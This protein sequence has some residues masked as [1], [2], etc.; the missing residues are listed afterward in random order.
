MVFDNDH[1]IAKMEIMRHVKTRKKFGS[2]FDGVA[3]FELTAAK[4]MATLLFAN[5]AH[6]GTVKIFKYLVRAIVSAFRAFGV[7]P[8]KLYAK[9]TGKKVNNSKQMVR[10]TDIVHTLSSL[11]DLKFYLELCTPSTGGKFANI[12]PEELK[13]SKR[14]MYL[15]PFSFDDGMKIDFRSPDESIAG[16]FEEFEKSGSIVDICLVD[17]WHT[18]QTA[19]RDISM[20]YNKLQDGGILVVHD[21]LP[22]DRETAQPTF[23]LGPWCGVSY[24]A[25]LDF[26]LIEPTADYLTINSDF[27]CGLIIKNQTFEAAL[28]AKSRSFQLPKRPQELL[29][30]EFLNSGQD[31]DKAISVFERNYHELLRLIEPEY[32]ESVFGRH[33]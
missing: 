5:K 3:N 26:V 32:F 30:L 8:K 22:P 27:G 13:E 33:D 6:E 16:A 7:D 2:F 19:S 20:A 9:I 11:F 25:F 14:L 31:F 18:Y 24:K 10:K 23:R 28:L 17:G 1:R 21:C 29:K 4:K 12:R 15:S